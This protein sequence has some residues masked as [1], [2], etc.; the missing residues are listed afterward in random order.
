MKPFTVLHE[1]NTI[2]SLQIFILFQDNLCDLCICQN[3]EVW[4]V[5]IGFEV[6]VNCI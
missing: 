3:K 5:Q 6:G 2:C 4:T 1:L